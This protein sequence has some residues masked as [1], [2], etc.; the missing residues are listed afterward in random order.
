MLSLFPSGL[1]P[2]QADLGIALAM[3][4]TGHS[5][6][7]T[8]LGALAGEVGA[9]VS[10]DVLGRTLGHAHH[11]LSGPAHIGALLHE[12]AAGSL[13]LGTFLGGLVAFMNITA[14]AAN[15]LAHS[16]YPP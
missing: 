14:N 7:H 10:H 11:V 2:V 12:L 9:Q 16:I 8:D 13:A 15:I 5:Q 4:H 1:F 3:G 6:V